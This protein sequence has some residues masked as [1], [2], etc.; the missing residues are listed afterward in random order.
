MYQRVIWTDQSYRASDYLKYQNLV[1]LQLDLNSKQM[2]QLEENF[3]SKSYR[4]DVAGVNSC[5]RLSCIRYKKIEKNNASEILME[6]L[7][8]SLVSRGEIRKR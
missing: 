7:N 6:L 1:Y 5:Y 2:K 4:K 3:R 8:I